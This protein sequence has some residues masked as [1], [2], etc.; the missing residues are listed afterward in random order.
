[1]A[2]DA[3]APT[4]H[5][6]AVLGGWLVAV[7]GGMLLAGCAHAPDPAAPDMQPTY[8]QGF[9][10]GQQ[11]VRR[12]MQSA[13]HVSSYALA[14]CPDEHSWLPAKKPSIP[15]IQYLRA[16]RHEEQLHNNCAARHDKLR[17]QT[18]AILG[19][20]RADR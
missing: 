1:M 19:L 6:R 9:A 20:I 8:A 10:D 7:F 3:S 13:A 4:G 12:D 16:L 2:N 15:R 18:A 17:A 14:P 5:R 11:S